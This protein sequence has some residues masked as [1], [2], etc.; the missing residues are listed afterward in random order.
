MESQLRANFSGHVQGVGFRYQTEAIS[1]NFNVQGYVQNM[2]D[3]T[4][5]LVFGVMG[6]QY[7]AC[8]HAHVISN[9]IDFGMDLQEALDAPRAFADPISGKLNLEASIPNSVRTTLAE[10]GHDVAEPE[11]AIGGAQAIFMDNRRGILVG[12]SDHRKDG[13]AVGY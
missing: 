10:M 4:V 5:D 7:Q 2:P 8:G 13:Q 11:T 9:M 3:G 6:G 1:R 12:A